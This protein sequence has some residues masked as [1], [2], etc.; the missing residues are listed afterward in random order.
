MEN[1]TCGPAQL[2]DFHPMTVLP[3][4]SKVME[5]VFFEYLVGH[6]T[7]G[8]MLSMFQSGLHQSHS[9]AM[10]LTRILD[11]IHRPLRYMVVVLLDFS[12]AFD[13]M[14]H[15]LP[16]RKLKTQFGLSSTACRLIGSFLCGRSQR[17]THD[18]YTFE[19]VSIDQGSL[20]SC[21]RVPLTTYVV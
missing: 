20:M 14:S 8:N 11:D 5:R 17:V 10:A 19:T 15:G 21:L 12:K 13:S 3:V 9:K 1:R 2:T 7:T 18:N 6:L 16:L 4:L